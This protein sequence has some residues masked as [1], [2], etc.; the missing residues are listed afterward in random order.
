MNGGNAQARPA[1]PEQQSGPTAA[2]AEPAS[3]GG[4]ALSALGRGV[5]MLSSGG[6]RANGR[7]LFLP[8]YHSGFKHFRFPIGQIE[9]SG[10]F[11]RK[12][13]K[14]LLQFFRPQHIWSDQNNIGPVF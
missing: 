7:V 6:R 4:E 5:A 9:N 12:I 8:S 13:R 11:F 2:S 3:F 10:Q 1:F 14:A